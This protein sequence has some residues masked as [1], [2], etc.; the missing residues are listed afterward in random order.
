MYF[1]LL[2]FG[3]PLDLGLDDSH[4]RGGFSKVLAEKGFE[5]ASS[6]RDS[7]VFFNLSLVL[8]PA[9][10][11][12]VLKERG[13]KGDAFVARGSGYVEIVLT[14]ST[15]VVAI[16]VQTYIV[17]VGVAGLEDSFLGCEV[18]LKLAML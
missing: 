13:R 7:I 16:H 12:F 6:R 8:L 1:F 17:Q 4:K 9:E 14:L 11:D 15:E 2:M 18:C 10:V 3:I 5:F